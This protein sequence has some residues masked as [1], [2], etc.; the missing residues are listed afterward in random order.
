MN[1]QQLTGT[2]RPNTTERGQRFITKVLEYSFLLRVLLNFKLKAT[3][4]N[5]RPAAGSQSMAA[6]AFGN[7]FT[8]GSMTPAAV[9]SGILSAHGFFLKYDLTYKADHELGI[10][11]HMDEWY[12]DNLD[13]KAYDTALAIDALI[14]AGSGT[15]NNM[16]GIAT[17]LDGTTNVPGLGITM[18][19][20]ALTGSGLSGNSF[21]LSDA[22]NFDTFLEQLDKWKGDVM[23][24]DSI[25]CNESAAARLTTIARVKHALTWSKDEFGK[26]ISQVNGL[27]IIPV[28]D[29]T[30][31]S[32]EPDNAGTPANVTTSIY[33]VRN[34]EG[35]WNI[36]SNSG[37]AFYDHGEL[38]GEQ[39][40]G[41]GFEFRAKN[42]IKRKRAL[43]RVRNIKLA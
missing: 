12:E 21:D 24:A 8:A 36:N 31:T 30:I 4:H 39:Q 26:P 6:R 14:I 25:I 10:G 19:I 5:Y 42:E 23:G 11:I 34:G 7:N 35:G 9:L 3:E 40:E 29:A 2:A 27:N 20:D 28:D 1:I 37:L 33:V 17:I 18:V 15:G 43:R 41:I 22:A 16:A 32:I 38:P 13:D